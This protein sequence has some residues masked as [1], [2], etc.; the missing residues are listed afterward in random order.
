M[1]RCPSCFPR[2]ALVLLICALALPL[3]AAEPRWLATGSSHFYVVTDAG[4]KKGR[5]VALRFE[6]MRA[7]FAQLLLRTRL[8]VPAPLEI[9]ALAGAQAYGQTAPL[10]GPQS[11]APGFLLSGDDRNYIVLNLSVN[12]SWSAVA[13]DFARLLLSY[14]YPPTQPWF[15]EG[16]AAYFSSVQADNRQAQI[17]IP[18]QALVDLLNHQTWL[19]LPELMSAK[20][21][22]ATGD[23]PSLF[24]AESWA[25]MHYLL[26]KNKLPETGTYFGLVQ[27]QNVAVPQAVQQAYGV[28]AAQFEQAVR[29]H[30]RS[31]N[32]PPGQ[33]AAPG[34]QIIPSPVGSEN[35]PASTN[36]VPDAD[37]DALLAEIRLRMPERR[38]QAVQE[39]QGMTGQVTTD[40]AI[41]HRALAWDHLQKQE[42]TQAMEELGSAMQADPRDRWTRYYLSL[43]KYRAGEASDGTY[44]GL[45]NMMQDLRIALDWYPEFAEAYNMLAMARVQGGGVNSAMEAMR[46][47]VRLCPRN[48]TYLLNMARIYMAG[49]KW[50]AA[51]ELLLRLTGSSDPKIVALARRNLEDLPSLRKYGIAPRHP[52]DTR[53]QTTPLPEPPRSAGAPRASASAKPA[54]APAATSEES[55]GETPPPAVPAPD[56]RPIKFLKGKLAAVDCSQAPVAVLTFSAGA[57]TLRLRT[58][59]FKSLLLIGAGEFSCDWKNRGAAVNYRSGGKADGDLV[60]LELQ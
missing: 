14:N 37:G 35:F 52:E 13:G 56:K 6:Q 12:D 27:N 43:V 30:F 23:S 41:V 39:L 60:S 59:D 49:K 53:K 55:E 16:F 20:S 2:F 50:E 33:Q 42:Y 4:D 19:P 5:E 3:H 47:A 44:P 11:A 25:L 28:S 38:T 21:A 22:P 1:G 40:S 51:T 57:K 29:D 17:G 7:I 24:Q 36:P 46:A 9:Y 15:D 26:D 10:H 45:A 18:P 34:T 8:N 48:Q 32:A 58:E 54:T 31:L